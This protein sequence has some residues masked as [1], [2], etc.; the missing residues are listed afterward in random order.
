MRG[1]SPLHPRDG[2]ITSRD[3]FWKLA[4]A[5]TVLSAAVAFAQQD[6]ID[7]VFAD[8]QRAWTNAD[9]D[10]VSKLASDDLVWITRSGRVLNKQELI[11]GFNPKNGT[12]NIRDKNVRLYGSVAVMTYAG[13]E[14]SSAIRRTIVWNKTPEGWKLVSV[15]ATTIPQ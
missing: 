14:G 8:Y 13:D 5:A 15:Q 7:K 6:E 12:K 10:A 3:M 9:K 11:Q 4:V 2:V 1:F